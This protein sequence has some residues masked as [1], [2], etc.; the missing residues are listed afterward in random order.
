MITLV[1]GGA[2]YIG[3]HIVYNLIKLGNDVVVID[4]LC[5]SKKITLNKIEKLTKKKINFY[6]FDVNNFEKLEKVFQ[7]NNIK[8]VIHLAGLKSVSESI[9]KPAYYMKNNYEGSI[10]L[11]NVMEKYNVYKLIFSSS[12]TVYGEPI[13]LPITEENP[14]NPLNPYGLS[15]SKVEDYMFNLS[16][17]SEYWKFISLRYFNPL[18]LNLENFFSDFSLGKHQNIMPKLLKAY[19]NHDQYFEIYGNDYDTKDGSGISDYIHIDDLVEGHICALNHLELIR[20][21]ETFNLGTGKGYSVYELIKCFEKITKKKLRVKISPRRSGDTAE[22][23]ASSDKANKYL[24][25]KPKKS[26]E[27]MVQSTI[28]LVLKNEDLK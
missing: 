16:K 26:L 22:L 7:E 6:K 23:Y 14:K 9:V 13:Q 1:T 12:A 11:L 4:N 8:N 3:S 28:N 2:G 19:L 10:N 18:G 24:N 27:A 20:G 25:W 21:Y 15:K 17:D 5:R